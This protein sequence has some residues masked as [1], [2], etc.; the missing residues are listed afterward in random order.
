[1]TLTTFLQLA[2]VG[3]VLLAFVEDTAPAQPASNA[4][5]AWLHDYA[6]TF[7]DSLP[8]RIEA[9][10][11]ITLWNSEDAITSAIAKSVG[12]Y[13]GLFEGDRY[14]I[15]A[16]ILPSPRGGPAPS[17]RCRS[18][19]DG[20]RYMT[21]IG[22]TG[23]I[24]IGAQA[25]PS[26]ATLPPNPALFC[27]LPFLP[28][29]TL[30]P[31]DGGVLTANRALS[32]AVLSTLGST[33]EFTQWSDKAAEFQRTDNPSETVR[34]EFVLME[35]HRFPA[36]LIQEINGVEQARIKFGAWKR[37]SRSSRN[38]WFP[39]RIEF[40][41]LDTAGNP[42]VSYRYDVVSLELVEDIPSSVFVLDT[43]TSASLFDY[44]AGAIVGP[45]PSV[46]P[47]DLPRF[48]E[49]SP[50]KARRSPVLWVGIAVFS[51]VTAVIM[52]VG[53]MRRS[54]GGVNT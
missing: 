40:I 32:P 48:E 23:D 20:S 8:F 13:R 52:C 4:P 9:E 17:Y 54:H 41:S 42:E 31:D 50:T 45:D 11:I 37:S 24:H 14:R 12:S 25:K 16:A 49:A 26:G 43:N 6:S 22:E 15:E 38:A 27:V 21:E 51:V 33:I 39:W 36:E 44:D 18:V 47:V 35:G 53:F 30:M 29:S 46:P 10:A 19:Y 2:L 5:E 3:S 1:M 34:V 28:A 7:Q